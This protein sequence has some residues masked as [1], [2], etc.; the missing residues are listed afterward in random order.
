MGMSTH[1]QTRQ[2]KAFSRPWVVHMVE[3]NYGTCHS[4]SRVLYRCRWGKG[5]TLEGQTGYSVWTRMCHLDICHMLHLSSTQDGCR[6][7]SQ[8]VELLS[9]YQKTAPAQLPWFQDGKTE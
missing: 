9:F 7:I 4:H 6:D 2:N 5:Y 8:M 3:Y 1:G